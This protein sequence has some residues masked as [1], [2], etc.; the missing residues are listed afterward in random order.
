MR[1]ALSP[2]HS[3]LSLLREEC[4]SSQSDELP[5]AV[6]CA[7]SGAEAVGDAAKRLGEAA[8]ALREWLEVY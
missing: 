4:G 3:P 1:A 5:V 2:T 7:A 6:S 8:R